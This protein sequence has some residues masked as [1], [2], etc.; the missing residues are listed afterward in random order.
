MCTE[1]TVTSFVEGRGCVLR[2]TGGAEVSEKVI[3]KVNFGKEF[4]GE[5]W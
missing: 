2:L 4:E 5:K 3:A 1:E